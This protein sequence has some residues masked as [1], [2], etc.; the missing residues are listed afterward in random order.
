MSK[1]NRML[2]TGFDDQFR[3][4]IYNLAY[5]SDDNEMRSLNGGFKIFFTHS[6]AIVQLS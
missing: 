3:K 6:S 1:G 4:L 2:M 5:N